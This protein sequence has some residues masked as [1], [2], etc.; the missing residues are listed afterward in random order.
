[1]AVGSLRL[2]WRKEET[3]KQQVDQDKTSADMKLMEFVFRMGQSAAAGAPNAS[4]S[5]GSATPPTVPRMLALQDDPARAQPHV[6]V[7]PAL[8]GV[9]A[10]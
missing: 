7:G 5:A 10:A 6:Q 4:T 8:S 1:M 3:S 9:P 2:R